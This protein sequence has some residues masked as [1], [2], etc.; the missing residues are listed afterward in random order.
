VSGFFNFWVMVECRIV[1]DAGLVLV[2]RAFR[3]VT[4]ATSVDIERNLESL[5]REGVERDE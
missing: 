3:L 2:R 5:P 4:A 1:D